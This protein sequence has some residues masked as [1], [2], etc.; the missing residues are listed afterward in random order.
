MEVKICLF[1]DLYMA[2]F[3]KARLANPVTTIPTKDKMS[4]RSYRG[5][6]QIQLESAANSIYVE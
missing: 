6:T 3:T 2:I 4:Q 1:A 5:R